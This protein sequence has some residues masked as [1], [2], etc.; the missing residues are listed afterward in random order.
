MLKKI[1]HL[2][3]GQSLR[4]DALDH[5]KF[6]VIWGLPVLSSDA[7]S[8]VSYACEEILMVLIPVL[9]M[10][11]YGLLMKVGFAI[12]FLLFILV[13]SYRQTINCY[14]QGG[15]SYIVASDNLGKVFGLIAAASLAIDYV[16]TV[17]VSVCAG[18]AAITSAFPQLLSMRTGIALIIISL[19]TIGNLRGMKD[20]SVL[21]GIPT[22][23]FIITIL[24]L[25]VTGFVKVLIFH[26]TPAVSAAMPQY[27]ENAGLLLFLK[28]FSSGCTALTG[29]EAVSDG[30][31]NF[32]EPAQKNAKRVLYLLAGL[33]FVIF[34]G[35]SALAS[36]YHIIPN[37]NVTVIAMIAEAVFGNGTLLFYLVQVTTAVILTMAANTAFADL[38]LLLSILARDGFVPRQFMS[39]GSRLSFSNGILLLFFLSAALV[40]YFHASSHLLMPLYAVGVFLS[41]TL[42]QAGMFVRWVKRKEDKWKHKAFI[43]GAGMVITGITC[44]IIAASKFLHGAWIVLI[45]IPVL[46]YIMERIRRHYHYVKESL[47]IRSAEEL[48]PYDLQIHGRVILPVDSI[49]RSFLK[50]YH[51][52]CS[53]QV[54]EMEF[55]HVNTNAEATE[56][57]QELYQQMRLDIPLVV[58]DAPYR[59][60]N[61]MILHHV[62]EAQ[63]DLKKKESVTVILPQFV[64]K[65]KRFHALHNQ[66]SM[67]L[68]LQLSKLRNVS[69]VSVP[70]II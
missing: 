19:L 68:K 18:T 69:V 64:M 47:K 25:I 49:N 16:L 36:L 20:S 10:A 61:E 9:G 2:V 22:Y 42:S 59:N 5:E 41:F 54:R 24:L 62:K 56:K 7:I 4:S 15:G 66:T 43:N 39:R 6:S 63:N 12:V 46:V 30:I 35:I 45:C 28:A 23:L 13:F 17:A 40:I 11:S 44:I 67:Q 26:E 29:V 60:V 65:K 33:V 37:A 3:L 55:Y 53:L 21:F 70:Y 1:K 38:P 58:E 48:Q 50:A 32:R 34:L 31:P 27:V 14:P 8:S 57:L 51:Y 52:A